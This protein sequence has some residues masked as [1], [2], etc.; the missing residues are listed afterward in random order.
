M[1]G[2]MMKPLIPLFALLGTPCVLVAQEATVSPVQATNALWQA[3]AGLDAPGIR[4]AAAAGADLNAPRAGL[5]PL[6]ALVSSPNLEYGQRQRFTDCVA[7][8]TQAGADVH[9]VPLTQVLNYDIAMM[10]VNYYFHRHGVKLPAH[11]PTKM[12]HWAICAGNPE[13]VR[14][15]VECGA[16]LNQQPDPGSPHFAWRTPLESA[17]LA[18]GPHYDGDKYGTLKTMLDLGADPNMPIRGGHLLNV[19]DDAG[20]TLLLDAGAEPAGA[21]AFLVLTQAGAENLRRLLAAG[22]KPDSRNS[23]GKT[24]LMFSSTPEAAAVLL[25]AG[26]DAN[27]RD[28]EG[29]TPLMQAV[30]NTHTGVVLVLLCQGAD[31]HARDKRGWSALD[32][33]LRYSY[34]TPLEL[35]LQSGARLDEISPE[36][37]DF[38]LRQCRTNVLRK[39]LA[40]GY[41]LTPEQRMPFFL[42]LVRMNFQHPSAFTN[43]FAF[44]REIG[45]EV[46]AR[47]EQTQETALFTACRRWHRDLL[48]ELLAMGADVNATNAAGQ[49]ALQAAMAVQPQQEHRAQYALQCIRRLHAAGLNLN[50]CDAQGNTALDYAVQS[51][52]GCVELLRTLGAK[53]ASEL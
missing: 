51:M 3:I 13:W 45:A 52:P 10:P 41:E 1:P 33:C 4:Q 7:A 50:H 20:I 19:A 2:V 30:R 47:E 27:A 34:D 9:A 32:Y 53:M 28:T 43:A 39:L 18:G 48:K 5:S 17:L 15:A 8:L 37:V 40:S 22:L 38:A 44:A 6:A 35:L 26:A 24:P 16:N 36:S 11:T 23:A 14:W 25:Q 49:T 31:V 46:N 42:H 12:L 29:C 21:D